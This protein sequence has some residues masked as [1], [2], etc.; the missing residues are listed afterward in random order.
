M[1]TIIITYFIL[2]AIGN[3]G[4]K[5]VSARNG[6]ILL[7]LIFNFRKTL[8]LNIKILDIFAYINIVILIILELYRIIKYKQ[9]L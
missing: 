9:I 1:I 2:K 4:D 8:E 6:C 3:D 7:F 5:F